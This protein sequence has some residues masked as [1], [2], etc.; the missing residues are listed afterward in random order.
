MQRASIGFDEFVCWLDGRSYLVDH[1]GGKGASLNR[2]RSLGVSVPLAAAIP[3][4]VYRAF[5]QRHGLPPNLD[6]LA[7]CDPS[8][9]RETIL[10]ATLPEGLAEALMHVGPTFSAHGK[11]AVR[12][13]ST[14]EDSADHAFAGLHDTILNV[15]LATGW[16]LAVRQ[17]WES[18]WSD[19]AVSYR[20][21]HEMQAAPMEMAVVIQE[22]VFCDVSFVGFATDPITGDGDTVVITATWGLGEAVVAGLVVPDEI[23]VSR[24][25]QILEHRIG[26]KHLMVIPSGGGVQ[27]VPVP[28]VL[29]SQPVIPPETAREI[30]AVILS[31]STGLGFPADVE[32]GICDGVMQIFQARPITSWLPSSSSSRHVSAFTQETS[33]HVDNGHPFTI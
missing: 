3:T 2:M 16:E 22:M 19:R 9:I 17:C 11:V 18:L 24:S 21:E 4:P 30:A 7:A 13:S 33:L 8:T 28:R 32:G 25:G 14:A 20:R 29:R 5:A 1:V 10:S 31:L 15:E 27:C 12:S 26:A 6:A 23:R